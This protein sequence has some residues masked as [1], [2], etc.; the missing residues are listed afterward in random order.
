MPTDKVV[1]GLN[2]MTMGG[3]NG[4]YV[5][6]PILDG[7]IMVESVEESYRAG[8]NMKVPML[9]GANSLD[10]GFSF[11]KTMDEVMKPFGA[12]AEKAL[13]AYD[14]NKTGNLQAVGYQ[15]A[16]DRDHDRAGAVHGEGVRR[17]EPAVVSL[18]LLLRRRVDP[19]EDA[20]RAAR[21][22]DPVRVRHGEGEVRRRAH[23]GRRGRREGGQRLLGKL[24][25]DGEP[26]RR[27]SREVAGVQGR[28][29]HAAGL[30]RGGAEGDGRPVADAHGSHGGGGHARKQS[31]RVPCRPGQCRRG[32]AAPP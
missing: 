2:F 27:G 19:G 8:H 26:E 10:I 24:R 22:G 28:H 9:V 31:R 1:A 29:E 14:P 11:A 23:R 7:K 5:G 17:A 20:R 13:A 4:T 12:D 25:E 18:S 15:V 16:M 3:A 30:H 21:D 6:G 32:L